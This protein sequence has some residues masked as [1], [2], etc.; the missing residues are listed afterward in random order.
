MP[1]LR[2]DCP[3]CD[4][5]NQGFD[6]VGDWEFKITGLPTINHHVCFR[7]G[8]CGGL[9]V[10]KIRHQGSSKPGQHQGPIDGFC[11]KSGD[12]RIELEYP[13]VKPLDCP[14]DVPANV[15]N[16]FTLRL[17][18]TNEGKRLGFCRHGRAP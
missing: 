7:C 4:T 8:Q 16:S 5:Q 3:H 11:S 18:T 2:R 15:R 9:Y 12:A 14:D 10:V 17:E 6:H 13:E 1:T